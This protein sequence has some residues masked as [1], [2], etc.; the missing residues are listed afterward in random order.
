MSRPIV[1]PLVLGRSLE[2]LPYL[3]LGIITAYLRQHRDGAL[4][5]DYDISPLQVAGCNN[6]PVANIFRQLTSESRAVCLFSS[7]VWNHELNLDVARKIRQ[8]CPHALLIF[9]GPHVPKYER[10]THRFLEENPFIDVA[11]LGEGEAACAEL[12][13]VLGGH[14]TDRTGLSDVHGIAYRDGSGIH[15]TPA[16]QRIRGLNQLP[17][18]YLTGEFEPWLRDFPLTV[19]ETNRGCPFGCTYCDWGS[20][21]LEQ[22]TKFDLDRVVAEIDYLTRH[23][24]ETIFIAD[25]NFGMLEQDVAVA[26]ALV[27]ARER[28]GYP[29][30]LFTNFAKNGGRRLMETI[31]ILHAGGLLPTGIIALQTTDPSVLAA[32]RRDNIKTSSF[33]EMMSFFHREKIPMASDLMIGLPGQTPASFAEDLQFCFDWKVSAHGNY[34]SLMPNAP[35]AEESY[36]REHEIETDERSMVIATSTFSREDMGEMKQLYSA[37]QFFVRLGVFRYGLY[38][39]QLEHGIPAITLLQEW[40][41]QP[42]AQDLAMP[43]S[44]RVREQILGRGSQHGDWATL[45]WDET[46][47]FLFDNI[48]TF[49]SELFEFAA[50]RFGARVG[51]SVADTLIKAQAAVMPRVGRQYPWTV[52]LEHDLATYLNQVR[53]APSLQTLPDNFQPLGTFR[54][55]TLSV[56]VGGSVLSSIAFATS[57]GHADKWELP[58]ALRFY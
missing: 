24:S 45:C 15:R 26:R 40:L 46:A 42:L 33:E 4:L 16:R 1:L 43:V 6:Q 52:V 8:R 37:Y 25:A 29:L 55:S 21:T 56:N 11:V 48:E 35:M 57:Q 20:A 23:R 10:D 41:A 12:L 32:I 58:S 30:R 22:V 34:T 50:R 51:T 27:A 53:S 17:S 39:L 36:L 3:S 9:G 54:A 44:L 13:Q 7:Y 2:T 28:H 38:Y 31:K 47:G 18:P 19:L 5:A 14:F 49:Y